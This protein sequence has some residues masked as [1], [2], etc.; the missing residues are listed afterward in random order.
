MTLVLEESEDISPDLLWPILDALRKNN[1]VN[2]FGY[3]LALSSF[4][5]I[6][7]ATYKLYISRRFCQLQRNCLR[8]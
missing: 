7:L 1:K 8:E 6:L 3:I 2:F 5:G 4:P